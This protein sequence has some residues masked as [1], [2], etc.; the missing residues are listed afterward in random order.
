M[1]QDNNILRAWHSHLNAAENKNDFNPISGT[2][3]LNHRH[4]KSIRFYMTD[5]NVN[6]HTPDMRPNT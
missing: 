3:I 6:L 5:A 1:G 2:L 4:H